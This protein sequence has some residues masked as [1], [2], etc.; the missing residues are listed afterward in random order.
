MTSELYATK[1]RYLAL[2]ERLRLIAEADP[3]L[4]VAGARQRTDGR[5]TR[6]REVVVGAKSSGLA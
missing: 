5:G 3:S 4:T 6:G 2:L 1:F